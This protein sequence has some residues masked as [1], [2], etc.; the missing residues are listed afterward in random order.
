MTAKEEENTEYITPLYCYTV[1]PGYDG[2]FDMGDP[3]AEWNGMGVGSIEL[4]PWL[5][6]VGTTFALN[7]VEIALPKAFPDITYKG[8]TYTYD[9]SPDAPAGTYAIDWTEIAV[10]PGA[11]S[12]HNNYNPTISTYRKTI[13]LNGYIHFNIQGRYSVIFEVQEPGKNGFAADAADSFEVDEGTDLASLAPD[14]P[15]EKMYHGEMYRFHAWYASKECQD[16]VD[17]NQTVNSDMILYGKYLPVNVN[18]LYVAKIVHNGSKADLDKPFTFR[19]KLFEPSGRPTDMP[20]AII[21]GE[22]ADS[23]C[24]CSHDGWYE[25]ELKNDQ[26]ITL[27]IPK[28]YS[29]ILREKPEGDEYYTTWSINGG[30]EIHETKLQMESDQ[31][32]DIVANNYFN[33]VVPTAFDD[34]LRPAYLFL[35]SGCSAVSVWVLVAKRK[36]MAKHTRT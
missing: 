14:L 5:Y 29:F 34:H 20:I 33:V 8:V 30:E 35:L 4:I 16:Q 18:Q 19:L 3:N 12:G 24:S 10:S 9:D 11:N 13:H 26:Y 23:V 1:L 17:L 2:S 21:S 31:D 6:P 28:N 32:Y 22:E 27:G 25:F 7:S 36:K 15:M